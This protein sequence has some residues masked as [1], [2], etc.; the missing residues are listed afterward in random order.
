MDTTR[1]IA[2]LFDLDGVV[3]DTESQYSI[4]WH[5]QGELYRPDIP[6]FEKYIKGMTLKEILTFFAVYPGA[7]DRIVHALNKYEEHMEYTYIPGVVAFIRSLREHG[8]KTAVVTSS[9]KLKMKN[10]YSAHAEFQS[11]FD[12]IFTAEDFKRSKPDPDCYLLGAR[13]FETVSSNCF[14]FEDSYHGLE[15]GNRAHM[16]VIGL[17]TTNPED[18]IRSRSAFVIPDFQSFSVEKMLSLAH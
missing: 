4:F 17:S 15:A 16:T 9:N 8:I 6:N 12:H 7:S 11:L 3:L 1:P 18:E 14:V 10:V 2:A 5:K 13:I